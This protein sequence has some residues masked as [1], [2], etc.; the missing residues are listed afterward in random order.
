MFKLNV[1]VTSVAIAYVAIT[2]SERVLP[3]VLSNSIVG[4]VY[5]LLEIDAMVDPGPV[6]LGKR[7]HG[8]TTTHLHWINI[9]THVIAPI[10]LYRAVAG[11]KRAMRTFPTWSWILLECM[12][13]F[14]FEDLPL[15]Y[16]TRRVSLRH[17]VA[18]HLLILI[19][20]NERQA[21]SHGSSPQKLSSVL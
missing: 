3:L 6:V 10:I 20:I 9:L 21:T 18:L 14:V 1:H 17:Y 12:A 15:L 7:I 11:G 8:R 2:K 16:P 5:T 19:V 13:W 4:F